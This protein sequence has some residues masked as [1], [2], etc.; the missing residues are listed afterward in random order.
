M[1]SRLNRPATAIIARVL[2][3]PA[4]PWST[5]IQAAGL[6]FKYGLLAVEE[7]IGA[8]FLALGFSAEATQAVLHGDR[9]LL[10][11]DAGSHRKAA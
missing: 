1:N 9:R 5:R 3:N 4:T 11:E 10:D 6:S 2:V 7:D 8:R